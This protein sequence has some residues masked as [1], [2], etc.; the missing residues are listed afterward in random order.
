MEHWKLTLHCTGHHPAAGYVLLLEPGGG[1]EQ[2]VSLLKFKQQQLQI[3]S[4]FP[5]QLA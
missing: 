1:D 5:N 2:G 4:D 3:M